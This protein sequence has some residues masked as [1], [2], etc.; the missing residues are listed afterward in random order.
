[1][2]GAFRQCVWAA[3]VFL[4]LVFTAWAQVPARFD[5]GGYSVLGAPQLTNEEFSRI[6]SPYIGRQKTPAD[7]QKAQQAL[8]QAY[9]DLGHC[10]TQVNLANP[11]PEAGVVTFRLVQTPTP[12]NRDCVPTVV[13]GQ[14][15]VPS[16]VVVAPGEVATR[17]LA[18]LS[19][20]LAE[21][22]AAAEPKTAIARA[23]PKPLQ[24]RPV[25]KP[26]QD[27]PVTSSVIAS[28]PP[29]LAEGP[30]RTTE[31]P[32]V[33]A[34]IVAA[35][36]LKPEVVTRSE[37]AVPIPAKP[38]PARDM[39][40][41][42]AV[43]PAES[44]KPAPPAAIPK[45]ALIAVAP[46][47]EPVA[48]VAPNP[49]PVREVVPQVPVP[50]EVEAP[51]PAVVAVAPRAEA[52]AAVAPKAEP[53][54]VVAPKPEP[55]AAPKVEVA[56]Q[57]EIVT[58][59]APA[60]VIVAKSEPASV[61]APTPEPVVAAA[62]KPGPVVTTVP[63]VE[64]AALAAKPEPVVVIAAKPEPVAAP[65]IEAVT[66]PERVVKPVRAPVVAPPEPA[67]EAVPPIAVARV[68]ETPKPAVPSIARQ[69][70]PEAIVPGSE[71]MAKPIIDVTQRSEIA[72]KQE[73]AAAIEAK[74]EPLATPPVA[75][76]IAE[77][78][79]PVAIV[80][81]A[82]PVAVP[83][84]EPVVVAKAE[85]AAE[86]APALPPA[87]VVVVKPEPVAAA[88]PPP[89]VARENDSAKP[90][91]VALAPKPDALA[92]VEAKPAA[93]PKPA[94]A[95][96]AE[97]VTKPVPV[98]VIVK[99]EPAPEVKPP[100]VAAP[101]VE[102]PKP[103]MVVA[104]APKAEV[105]AS[106]APK[107]ES[108]ALPKAEIAPPSEVLVRP[109]AD[110]AIQLSPPPAPP[111]KLEIEK[112]P[113]RPLQ[114]PPQ[115]Q[116]K[117]EPEAARIAAA[118]AA[119]PEPKPAASPAPQAATPA[120][121]IYVQA[122][123]ESVD[124]VILADDAAAAA[125]RFDIARY[126]IVGNTM[127]KQDEI[128]RA[129]RPYTGRQ[130]DFADVQRALESL[131]TAYADKGYSAVQV[132]LPE[133]ELERGEVRFEVVETRLGKID[134]Q[135]NEL[136]SARNVRNSLPSL[137]AG[138][139]PNSI[140]IARN[141][142]LANEN[143]SKQ[144]QVALRA[145]SQD[146]EVDATV[147]LIED[148]PV[149]YSVSAD[150][151]GTYASGKYRVGFGY[152]N[153]NVFDRD[154]TLTLQYITSP[155]HPSTVT[156]LGLGYRVPLYGS[157][158][159]VDF[160]AGYSDVSSGTVNQLFNVSGAGTVF[161]LR[162]NHNLDRIDN[163][164]HKIIYGLDYKAFKS[165]VTFVGSSTPL[166]PDITVRPVSISYTGTWRGTASQLDFYAT[167]SQNLFPGG[168]DGANSDFQERKPG[169]P[170]PARTEAKAGYNIIR[171]GA[172]YTYQMWGEWQA[173]TIFAIQQTDAALVAGEQFGAGG[174]ETVRGFDER[175]I[176]NDRGWRA[177]FELYTP[178]IAGNLGWTGGR[179]KLLAF[180]DTAD[181]TRNRVQAGES[182]GASIASYGLGLRLQTKNVFSMK[183]DYAQVYHDGEMDSIRIL[184]DGRRNSNTVHASMV[185]VF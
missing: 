104:I 106:V 22:P 35:P 112:A 15:R 32:L 124:P 89:A 118:P 90:A 119:K 38:E 34:P 37:P 161:G 110:A 160:V 142:R 97:V 10:S 60:P 172:N 180:Y 98:P 144:T 185:W 146:G 93:A 51:K 11:E 75:V 73:P 96:P 23:A 83:K 79:R 156:V 49:E 41:S 57:A 184:K 47:P 63:K 12:M 44:S 109:L 100:A 36:A 174:A 171:A 84:P 131:Q 101:A 102:T 26:L 122:A 6:V 7:V 64:V 13:L 111:P 103:A 154:H 43:T 169:F 66:P 24:D 16:P 40:P 167:Y 68:V 128:S 120:A 141:L 147:K 135:G 8:Q 148:D 116:S 46:K 114:D 76:P 121:S 183:V 175:A 107:P 137:R 54:V 9:F 165:N 113:A 181:L 125:L 178:D 127:L 48:A 69:P 1:M 94:T 91:V 136:H 143:A 158:N 70:E 150:N 65:R 88:T 72:A 3:A 5:I 95:P 45:P 173:R 53:V 123:K 61:V 18:D 27:P 139:T 33:A 179:I 108:V 168:N 82:E 163:L 31:K 105:M 2:V 159:S 145:G 164:E 62:P 117:P 19:G 177:T 157:G 155:E 130:K 52:V 176:S 151:T 56:P 182:S 149:K 14:K 92:S 138:A 152:Q 39:A 55:L 67:R 134:I 153:A 115:P 81:K 85:I 71:P 132:T 170:N 50:R 133:Q 29:P 42:L 17:P 4:G 78:P 87:E 77:I 30:I 129:L 166:V 162:Y 28:A 20:T 58:K 74:P 86:P 59:P 21:A 99:P 25:V 80:P 126:N 140:E